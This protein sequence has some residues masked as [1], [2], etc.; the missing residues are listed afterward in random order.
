MY[1]KLTKISFFLITTCVGACAMQDDTDNVSHKHTTI[2][3]DS[4]IETEEERTG[5]SN[6]LNHNNTSKAADTTYSSL[7]KYF[8]ASLYGA[9]RGLVGLPIEHPFDCLKTRTQANLKAPS[10][11]EVLKEI[12]QQNGVRGFYAGAIPNGIRLAFKQTYRWP[13]ML[14]FPKFYNS[15]LSE[16]VNKQLPSFKKALTGVTIASLETLIICPLER[17]KV[18]LM[19]SYKNDKSLTNFFR[20]NKGNLGTQLFKG[21]NASYPRQLTA[22]V[23]F[24]VADDKFKSMARQYS[25]KEELSFPMLLAV[26][27]LVGT[28]NTLT[29]MPFD[30]MKTQFQMQSP[31]ENRGLINAMKYTYKNFGM[32][33]LYAGWQPRML[34]YMIQSVFTVSL[35]DKLEKSWTE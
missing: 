10:T 25:G 23:I 35:L 11:I 21:L 32:R 33:G 9:V 13:M 4:S 20:E 14:A 17:L 12:Y 6:L 26:S 29:T 7:S 24:L 8:E 34:Q 28:T 30:C 31:I 15:I 3:L 18:W 5:N 1:I 19:T 22:W 2:K 16:D 27:F